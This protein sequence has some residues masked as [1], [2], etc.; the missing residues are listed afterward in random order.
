MFTS[1]FNNI[2]LSQE[3]INANADLNIKDND[4]QTALDHAIQYKH[5]EI[6]TLIQ[7]KQLENEINEN[8]QNRQ[9]EK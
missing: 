5:K 3:L 9:K 1:K 4:G 6:I 7:R 2:G 8:A